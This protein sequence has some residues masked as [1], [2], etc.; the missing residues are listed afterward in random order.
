MVRG[1][2]FSVMIGLGL[3]TFPIAWTFSARAS[4]VEAWVR[5]R[6]GVRPVNTP[7]V[8]NEV[9]APAEDDSGFVNP[10]SV[11]CSV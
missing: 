7:S 5:R 9:N 1:R 11:H 2:N 3:G 8:R 10:L 4:R 6:V